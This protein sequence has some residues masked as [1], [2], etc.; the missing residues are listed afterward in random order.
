M[1]AIV[2]AASSLIGVFV[3]AYLSRLLADRQRR[4]TTTFDLH[5]ELHSA[6]M[7]RAR[8]AAAGII[9]EHP[10]ADYVQL[11]EQLG[12]EG[13]SDLRQVIYFFQRLWIAIEHNA[14]RNEYVPRLFGDTFSW[15]YEAT[16]HANLVSTETE[17]GQDIQALHRWLSDNATP[18]QTATWRGADRDVWRP[19]R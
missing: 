18:A 10:G 11:Q 19:S 15:W 8:Y 1:D 12:S 3:G 16:F 4:L 7:I 2:G 6:D 13:I 14:L 17:V 5:R 9:A